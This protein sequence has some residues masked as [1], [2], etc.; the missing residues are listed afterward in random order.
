M[1]NDRGCFVGGY[2]KGAKMDTAVKKGMACYRRRSLSCQAL[3][4]SSSV[5]VRKLG[6]L[7]VS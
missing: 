3:S 5:I 6:V 7:R 1:Q 4:S 2:K